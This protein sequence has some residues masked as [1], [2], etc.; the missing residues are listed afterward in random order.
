MMA[1]PAYER[2]NNPGNVSLPIRGWTGGGSVVGI[3]GQPGYAS[4]PDMNTG[5]AAF[6]QRI[7]T[8][9]DD[10]YNTIR[11]L[12]PIY[13]EDTN[14]KFGVSRVSGIGLDDPLNESNVNDLMRGIITQETG[15]SP[16][17]LGINLGAPV[18]NVAQNGDAEFL[19]Y[20]TSGENNRYTG[21]E[22]SDLYTGDNSGRA[23]NDG[24]PLSMSSPS[25][26]PRW[27]DADINGDGSVS[28]TELKTYNEAE[29]A[30][31]AA[32]S[33]NA[34]SQGSATSIPRAIVTAANQQSK[35]A[36]SAAETLAQT[37]AKNTEATNATS[38]GIFSG[39]SDWWAN[40]LLQIAVFILAAIFVLIGLYMFAPKNAV[41][42]PSLT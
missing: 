15:R 39:W 41:A 3:K 31:K 1:R 10:G 21:G 4:F 5:V 13:A 14:W 22:N 20:Q 24:A 12:N 40:R 9:L 33:G 35:A 7:T 16:S 38:W 26:D 42:V 28:V 32:Q 30:S 19:G 23:A 8:R 36:V 34:G 18:T 17:Q 25:T 27:K 11:K 29:A 6:R 2:Y 37:S